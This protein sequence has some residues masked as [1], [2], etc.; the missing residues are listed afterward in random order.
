MHD[1]ERK[2]IEDILRRI[3]AEGYLDSRY[4]FVIE[5]DEL[6][7]LGAGASSLVYEMYDKQAADR[8]YAAKIIGFGNRNIDEKYVEQSMRAQSFLGEQS[9][10]IMRAIALWT[11]NI[12]ELQL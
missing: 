11:V 1:F 2:E 12:D 8:H 6:K 5:N 9:E 4:G 3:E 10:H 7:L